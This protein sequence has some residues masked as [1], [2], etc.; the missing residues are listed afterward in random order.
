MHC[1]V[2]CLGLREPAE[3]ALGAGWPGDSHSLGCL[4]RQALLQATGLG[5]TRLGHGSPKLEQYSCFCPD[6]RVD[7]TF[8]GGGPPG[9]G[10][11]GRGPGW[12]GAGRDLAT[13]RCTRDTFHPAMQ[14]VGGPWSWALLWEQ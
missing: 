2:A 11:G 14:W 5:G 13:N 12:R 7:M 4:S 1:P 3:C 10:Q 9:K 8:S 6:P